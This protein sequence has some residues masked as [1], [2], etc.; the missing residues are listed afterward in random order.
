VASKKFWLYLAVAYSICILILSFINVDSFPE[1]G[2]DYDDKIFH[3]LAYTM[4]TLLWFIAGLQW[5]KLDIFRISLLVFGYGMIIEVFQGVFAAHREFEINDQV[6][7]LIGITL[8]LP[9]FW[10][11]K[12]LSVKKI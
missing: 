12:R 8:A 11:W 3:T 4:L 1:I 2:S 5:R 7:N 9:L 6:A 10:L